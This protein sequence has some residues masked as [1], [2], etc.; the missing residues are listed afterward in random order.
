MPALSALSRPRLPAGVRERVG[1]LGERYA[2]LPLTGAGTAL[3]LGVLVCGLLGLV[4][5]WVEAL[6]AAV[7][8]LVIGLCAIPFVVGRRQLRADLSVGNR[9]VVVGEPANGELT[10]TN[11]G[12]RIGATRMDLPV[13]PDTAT[14]ELPSLGPGATHRELFALPTMRRARLVVGPA[15][16]VRADP[17]G[18]L[19]REHTW[20]GTA[21]V[22]VHPR[23]TPIPSSGAGF[24]RDLEG[25]V[26]DTVSNSDVSF[27][28][29]RD[30]VSGDDRR[31]VHWRSTAHAGSLMV[32]QFEE[33]RRSYVA[34][35]LDVEHRSWDTDEQFERGVE[36]AA[37]LAVQALRDENEV[38]VLAGEQRLPATSPQRALDGFSGIARGELPGGDVGPLARRVDRLAPGV[39]VVVVVTGSGVR[40]DELRQACATFG[41]DVRV[42]AIRVARGTQVRTV[43]TVT[44]AVCGGLPNLVSVVRR[45]VAW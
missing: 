45:A 20:T 24:V 18:V 6:V 16:S 39:S 9:R 43:G 21:D 44:T 11:A 22:Y 31:Y 2:G 27:H 1:A 41:P 10:I 12:K 7:A 25:R 19:S 42:L 36:V 15:R 13:G 29:L 34:V 14:F 40:E 23:T 8:G 26:T 32:R 38:I 28:A 33:T 35:A 17:F 30:Y 4:L 5:G 37:S 3:V